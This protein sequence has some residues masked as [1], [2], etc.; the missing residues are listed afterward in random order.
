MMS[1][2]LPP[3]IRTSNRLF[4]WSILPV[5]EYVVLHCAS[6]SITRTLCPFLAIPY[7]RLIVD[8]VFVIPPLLFANTIRCMFC[9]SFLN[10]NVYLTVYVLIYYRIPSPSESRQSEKLQGHAMYMLDNIH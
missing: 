10:E 3:L 9:I 2:I 1:A 8:V 6:V 7:P 4:S 5:R